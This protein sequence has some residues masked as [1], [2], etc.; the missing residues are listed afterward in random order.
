ME[1]IV[2]NVR[3]K[4]LQKILLTLAPREKWALTEDLDLPP[5]LSLGFR[6]FCLLHKCERFGQ[7]IGVFL[8]ALADDSARELVL[9]AMDSMTLALSEFEGSPSPFEFSLDELSENLSTQLCVESPSVVPTSWIEDMMD[10]STSERASVWV[11]LCCG[12]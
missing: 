1:Y 6:G 5:Q 3:V 12:G 8:T 11:E 2:V 4:A 7:M 10:D 9:V